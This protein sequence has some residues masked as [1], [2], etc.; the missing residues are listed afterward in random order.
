MTNADSTEVEHLV[1]VF[2]QYAESG[3]YADAAAMLYKD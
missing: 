1:N 2:F 3:K